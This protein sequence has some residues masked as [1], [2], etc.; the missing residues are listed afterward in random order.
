VAKGTKAATVATK[1]A[2]IGIFILGLRAASTFARAAKP[3][4]GCTNLAANTV[5]ALFPGMGSTH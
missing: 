5:G 2:A 3:E 4:P 1:A